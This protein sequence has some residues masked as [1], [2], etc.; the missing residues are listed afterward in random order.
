[1]ESICFNQELGE[2][3]L[4]SSGVATAI[5]MNS[6]YS[7]EYNKIIGGLKQFGFGAREDFDDRV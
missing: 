6:P 2:L 3:L 5:R 4:F 1:M 7:S